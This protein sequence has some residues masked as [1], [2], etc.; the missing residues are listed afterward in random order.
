M[1]GGPVVNFPPKPHYWVVESLGGK[2]VNQDDARRYFLHRVIFSE[3]CGHPLSRRWDK[4]SILRR[5][6]G[7]QVF[8]W[9][10]VCAPPRTCTL[11]GHR[12]VNLTLAGWPIL[13]CWNLV[14]CSGRD[15]TSRRGSISSTLQYSALLSPTQRECTCLEVWLWHKACREPDVSEANIELMLPLCFFHTCK[16]TN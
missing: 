10:H 12:C 11:N 15:N 16:I 5:Q 13:L 1:A 2:K 3:T 8:M 4:G 6:R 14:S 9:L 7:V